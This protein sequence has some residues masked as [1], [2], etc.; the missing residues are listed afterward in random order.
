MRV[1]TSA[2]F[3]E[4]LFPLQLFELRAQRIAAQIDGDDLPV[5]IQQEVVRDG[6]DT[7]HSEQTVVVRIVLAQDY[8]GQRRA[9]PVSLYGLL[10]AVQVLVDGYGVYRKRSFVIAAAASSPGI[11][12]RHGRHHEAQKSIST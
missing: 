5:G 2:A 4:T 12:S 3:P 9:A 7:E 10:P 1:F 8:M 6:L 11:S